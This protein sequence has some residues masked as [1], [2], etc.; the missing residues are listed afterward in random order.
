M[1]NIGIVFYLMGNFYGMP[2]AVEMKYS[3]IVFWPAEIKNSYLY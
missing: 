3:E 1:F 2:Q